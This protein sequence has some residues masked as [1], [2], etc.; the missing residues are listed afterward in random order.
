[1]NTTFHNQDLADRMAAYG[2]HTD[3]TV[4]DHRYH[5]QVEADRD[6]TLSELQ[7]AGGRVT[8]V[9]L[10]SEFIPGRGRCVD[11]SYVHGSIGDRIVRINTSSS[12]EFSLIPMNKIKGV[13]IEW[14]KAE[15]VFA[16]GLGLLDEANW[17]VLR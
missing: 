10:L 3:G 2:A 1:M 11:I 7:A 8:R 6:Y 12:P 13:F 17:S 14:A 5:E 4:V 9:R 15:G 16:K